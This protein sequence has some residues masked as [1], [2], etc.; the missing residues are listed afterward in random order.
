M[1]AITIWM[2]IAIR[3]K[4][5]ASRLEAIAITGLVMNFGCG[6]TSTTGDFQD[7]KRNIE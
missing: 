5:I 6:L 2:E 3:L 1:E 7:L 4:A